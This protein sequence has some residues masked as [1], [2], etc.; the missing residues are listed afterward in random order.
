M[1]MLIGSFFTWWYG[2]G[3]KQILKSLDLRIK[4]IADFFSITMLA[5]TL[6]APWKQIISYSGTSLDS[7]FRAMIDNLFSR[8]VGFAV[9]SLVL[10]IAFLAI[11]AVGILTIVEMVLWPILPIAVP[12]SLILG[13]VI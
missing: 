4:I 10:F 13:V 9:R 1:H 8:A 2:E 12:A 7:K 6:T 11:V 5:R 3:W